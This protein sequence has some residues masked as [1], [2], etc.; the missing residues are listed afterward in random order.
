[1]NI[2]TQLVAFEG[3]P[4]DP[5]RPV[6]TP[7]Y[8][9]ATFEQDSALEFGRYDYSR[10]GN[11]TRAVLE[12]QIA[13][14]EGGTRAFAFSSGLAAIAAVTR[15][16]KPGDEIVAG[17]DLYGGTYRL[18]S[19]LLE[20]QGVIVK[21]ADLA[22]LDEAR[23]A[24]GPRTR[25]VHC[26]SPTNP[27]QRVCDIRGL[28]SIAHGHGALL[29]VDA[30]AM[31]PY[32]MK[33]LELGADFSIHS[34]T[35]Y[36][37]GHSDVSAGSVS[38]REAG[39][40]ER[41]YLVQNGEGAGLAPFDSYLLLRG[42]KTLALRVEAQQASARR[43]AEY[44]RG[45]VAV[46]RVFF[47][48]LEECAGNALHASQ[49][50]GPGAVVSFTTGSLERSRRVVESLKLFPITVSFGGV[51]SSASLPCRMS[52]ASIPERV[53][54]ARELPEDLV[55]LSIGIEDV[56]DLIAD[57]DGAL[58]SPS[59]ENAERAESAEGRGESAQSKPRELEGLGA[60]EEAPALISS[61]PSRSS[62]RSS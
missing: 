39:I 31:S 53:R 47:V 50:R 17:D 51:G 1:M 48:G 2:R 36:L 7:I 61:R 29:S 5:F 59:Q 8:Q 26:E 45:H 40:A 56:Q 18:L 49:A 38:V 6:A 32:L 3:C 46:K 33:P 44:L 14:L 15:L 23:A 4:D 25:L 52:H 11:P 28:A 60:C 21:Y 12:A 41:L 62:V 42:M 30:T 57:L 27:L 24:I 55:R 34:A 58:M 20:P 19:R 22:D 16:V 54:L 35:K 37:C 10:S 13:R 9:T 43:I